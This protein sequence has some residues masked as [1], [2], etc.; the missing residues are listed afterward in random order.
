MKIF[1]YY[2]PGY[3][4]DNYRLTGTEW[5]SVKSCEARSNHHYQP[6]VPLDGYYDQSQFDVAKKQ[7]LT[8]INYG[9][10]GFMVCCY[11]DFETQKPIMDEPL[12][13]LLKASEGLDFE[14]NL[15]WVLRLPHKELPISF[16]NF[17]KYS[18]H[19][20]FIKR[21]Q[22]YKYDQ[23]FID[24]IRLIAQHP[25]YRK[26][27]LGKPLLQVYS[28]SEIVDDSM[29]AMQQVSRDLNTFHL[30]GICG[31]NDDWISNS[32][33]IGLDSI[34]S[35]VT[36]VDFNTKKNL[37]S[38]KE[39]VE[40]QKN[41]W[42][43]ILAQTTVPFYP[44]I[45]SGWDASARGSFVKGFK[46]NKFPWAPIVKNA[47]PTDFF[48]NLELVKSYFPLEELEIHIASWNEWSEGHYI[49]ADEKF[50]YGFLEAVKEFKSRYTSK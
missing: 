43:H 1:A 11:W 24:Y 16:G 31:R 47:N 23:Q 37:L 29:E 8:A 50:G 32:A 38:H 22:S 18:N 46:V 39:C 3:Y 4:N 42:K 49:E 28:V 44:S 30:Q 9:I 5:N 35:Y 25:N 41:V 40:D 26:D 2:Y 17:G 10:D 13:Q 34:S 14:I 48:T 20:W 15:M 33:E 12:K 21:I 19:P 6:R 7:I 36:L 45:S 27:S